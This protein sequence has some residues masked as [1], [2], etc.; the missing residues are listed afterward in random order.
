MHSRGKEPGQRPRLEATSRLSCKALIWQTF[1]R[2]AG[3]RLP[4]SLDNGV[5]P[6]STAGDY[7]QSYPQAVPPLK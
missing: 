7:A 2:T 1:Y 5:N 6:R 4:I 3:G